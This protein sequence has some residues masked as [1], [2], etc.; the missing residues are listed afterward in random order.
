MRIREKK[1]Q[2]DM[3]SF[4]LHCKY[5][6]YMRICAKQDWEIGR[7]GKRRSTGLCLLV[8]FLFFYS[9]S[10][11]QQAASIRVY[12]ILSCLIDLI[13]LP[14]ERERE[15]ERDATNERSVPSH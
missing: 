13:L 9:S 14:R 12:E 1:K 8:L 4:F 10:S 3:F 11:K 7:V 15:R 6:P 2:L 5:G